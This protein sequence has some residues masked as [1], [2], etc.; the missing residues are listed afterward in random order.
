MISKTRH[1]YILSAGNGYISRTE[2]KHV[3]MNLGE[4]LTE[5]ECLSLVEVPSHPPFSCVAIPNFFAF[6]LE[7]S[8]IDII[9]LHGRCPGQIS[10]MVIG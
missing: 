6:F 3:M 8:H 4:A 7:N 2:L 9:F 1:W 10:G 5:E